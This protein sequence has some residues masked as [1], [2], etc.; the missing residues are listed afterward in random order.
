M[1]V[2]SLYLCKPRCRRRWLNVDIETILCC[3]MRSLAKLQGPV[4]FELSKW[5][6]VGDP[7]RS[8]HC[9]NLLHVS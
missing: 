9:A 7:R 6:F 5:H 2:S 3:R 4:Q 1:P 8:N